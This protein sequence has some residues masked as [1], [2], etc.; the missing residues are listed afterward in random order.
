MILDK[1]KKPIIAY[2]KYDEK[3]FTQLYLTKFIDG[4]WMSKKISDWT[5]RWKFVGGGDKMTLDAI[6][7]LWDSQ[8]REIL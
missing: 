2:S 6:S 3:G 5:F 1:D 8:K 4:K 7:V